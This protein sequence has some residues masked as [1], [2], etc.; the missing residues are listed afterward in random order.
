MGTARRNARINQ[1]RS[2]RED[3]RVGAAKE[4]AASMSSSQKKESKWRGLSNILKTAFKFIDPTKGLLSAGFDSI[5]DPIGRSMGA[6][7]K[8]SDITLSDKYQ[9]YGGKEALKNAKEGFKKSLSDYKQSSI[10]NSILGFGASKVGGAL[11]D[12]VP[13]GKWDVLNLLKDGAEDGAVDG[14]RESSQM[15]LLNKLIR[16][17]E[18]N[19]TGGSGILTN[20]FDVKKY[21]YAQGGIVQKFVD[22][23]MVQKYEDGGTIDGNILRGGTGQRM[24]VKVNE[25]THTYVPTGASTNTTRRTQQ[26]WDV[27]IHEWNGTSWD[28][29]ETIRPTREENPNGSLAKTYDMKQVHSKA[30]ATSGYE[31]VKGL[32]K[33]KTSEYAEGVAE[34]YMSDESSRTN[35][36][37]IGLGDYKRSPEMSK[38]INDAKSGDETAKKN[39]AEVMRQYRPEKWGSSTDAEL[40][41]IMDAELTSVDISEES[42]GYTDLERDRDTALGAQ[43]TLAT[44]AGETFETRSKGYQDALK[45]GKQKISGEARKLATLGQSAYGGSGLSKRAMRKGAGTISASMADIFGDYQT[46][47]SDAFGDYTTSMGDITNRRGTWNPETGQYEGGSIQGSFGS[48]VTTFQEGEFSVFDT[49]LNQ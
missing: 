20:P 25:R 10:V 13:K 15:S 24:A 22:G 49:L 16:P 35:E 38:L 29:V 7:A 33:Y 47:K 34:T 26:I 37:G 6:G 23:G 39:L 28:I 42:Q 32:E 1:I 40:F 8:E 41:K 30:R 18:V 48:D 14:A 3:Y 31:T 5:I 4:L 11:L 2:T 46:E 17:S 43:D 12:K 9:I 19:R 27:Q 21:G 44:T 45:F 36:E